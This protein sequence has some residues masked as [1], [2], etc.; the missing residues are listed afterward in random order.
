MQEPKRIIQQPIFPCLT[1][2]SAGKL[3]LMLNSSF[4]Y[5]LAIDPSLTASGWSLFCFE[6]DKPKAVGVLTPP[7]SSVPLSERLAVLQKAIAQ[8]LADHALGQRD[9]MICEGPAPL[10]LNPQS[11]LK[12]ERVRSIFEALAR[13]CGMAVPGRLNPRTVQTELLGMRGRQLARIEVKR[14]ARETAER[15]FSADLPHLFAADDKK[16]VS[17]DIIDALLIGT[18]SVSK[19]RLAS[20][21]GLSLEEAFTALSSGRRSSR[22]WGKQ[23][24]AADWGEAGLRK[25]LGNKF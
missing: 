23:S 6:T 4:R 22:R 20:S 9:V 10:V 5:L 16:K 11:S 13:E 3:Q 8:L 18:L 1:F 24:I 15:L 12:V 7:K 17:Q 2:V 19:I 14:C 25:V 21:A